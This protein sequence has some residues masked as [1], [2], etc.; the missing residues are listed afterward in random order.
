MKTL[1]TV[2]RT[3]K[4]YSKQINILKKIYQISGGESVVLRM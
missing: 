2:Q 3:K 4:T 1:E